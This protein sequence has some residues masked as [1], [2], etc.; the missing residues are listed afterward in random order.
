[1][2]WIGSVPEAFSPTPAFTACRALT[3]ACYTGATSKA[4]P[5][6]RCF[7][8]RTACPLTAILLSAALSRL[9]LHQG[10][11]AYVERPGRTS[12]CRKPTAAMR[13]EALQEGGPKLYDEVERQHPLFGVGQQGHSSAR[14]PM[15]TIRI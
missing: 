2:W 4:R 9:L 14:R 5:R 10:R 11:D 12:F 13:E 6:R 1:M 3:P 8:A 15:P 7:L